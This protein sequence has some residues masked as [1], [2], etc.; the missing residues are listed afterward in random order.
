MTKGQL[1]GPNRWLVERCQ[2]INFGSITFHVRR[3]EPDL[4]RP[5]SRVR[6]LKIAGG[7]NGPRP[8]VASDD[9]ELRCEHIALVEQLKEL[10]D[11]TRVRVKIAHGLPGASI[12]LL[13]DQQAA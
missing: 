3:G 11:G 8:E 6:T 1:S 4:G 9:F 7:I 5:H 12:D 10:P 13:E 2:H